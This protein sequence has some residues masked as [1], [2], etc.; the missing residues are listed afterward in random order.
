MEAPKNLVTAVS[1][2]KPQAIL[3]LDTNIIMNAPRLDSYEINAPGPFLLV[4]PLVVEGELM[5][6]SRGG[7]DQQTRRKASRACK[8]TNNLYAQGNPADGID[9]GNDLWLITAASPKSPDSDSLEDEQV[10]R[11]LGKVDAAL[12]RLAIACEKDCPDTRVLLVTGDN[13]LTRVAKTRGLTACALRDLRSSEVLETILDATSTGAPELEMPDF[14]HFDPEEERPVRIEMRLEEL[15]SEGENLVAGGCGR[16]AYDER[17]FSFNWTFPF[18]DLESY[19]HIWNVNVNQFD[20]NVVM[21]LENL[22]FMGTD[23]QLPE[24]VKYLACRMLEDSGGWGSTRSLQSPL[25]NLRFSLAFVTAMGDLRGD[26]IRPTSETHKQFLTQEEAKRYDELSIPH[27]M[28]MRSLLDGTAESFGRTYRSV[29]PLSEELECLM[30]WGEEWYGP[31]DECDPTDLASVLIYFLDIAMDTWSV[32][33][34]REEKHV[35][36]PFAW[37]EQE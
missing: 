3:L 37:L 19:K 27:D 12:L 21:P 26:L 6:L 23:E 22:D 28:Y 11:N 35:V 18:R 31:N 30:G 29:F 2:L 34:T 9:L 36:R 24:P 15:K 25:T 16:I 13:D 8:E 33:E 10:L 20:E 4:V 17:E 7:K 5:S 32:G 14:A 1:H